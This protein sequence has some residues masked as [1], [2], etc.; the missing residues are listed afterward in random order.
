[1]KVILKILAC[2]V[3]GCMLFSI[4]TAL[5]INADMLSEDS[6]LIDSQEEQPDQQALYEEL[7]DPNSVVEIEI[8]IAREQI[9]DIQKDYEYYYGQ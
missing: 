4:M 7:F 8:H 9:A 3:A 6:V 2:L 1:M 5:K